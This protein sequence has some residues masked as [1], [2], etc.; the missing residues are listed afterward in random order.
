MATS[1]AASAAYSSVNISAFCPLNASIVS[2]WSSITA[3]T[4]TEVLT[5]YV[6]SDVAG[7]S[8]SRTLGVGY[9]GQNFSVP[10][11]TSQSIFRRTGQTGTS[12]VSQDIYI[13]GYEV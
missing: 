3:A 9:A 12:T 1:A 2:G 5:T 4:T 11:I 7:N 6:A 10:L 13:T 8:V